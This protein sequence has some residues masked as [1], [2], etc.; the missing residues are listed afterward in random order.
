L[1][2]IVGPESLEFDLGYYTGKEKKWI[3]SQ[4]DACDALDIL[5]SQNMLTLWYTG[6]IEKEKSKK[7]CS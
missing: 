6:I 1:E 5:K 3:N 7:H 2:Q 4:D